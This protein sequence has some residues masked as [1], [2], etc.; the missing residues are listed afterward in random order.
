MN[1]ALMNYLQSQQSNQPE[2]TG[3]AP[4]NPFD[5]GIRRAI[6]SAQESLGMT[7]KQ[8]DKALRRSILTFANHNAQQPKERGFFNNFASA[9]KSMSPAIMDYDQ[10]EDQ[11]LAENQNMANQILAYKAAEEAKQAGAE[12]Q[13][14]RRQHAENQLGEQKRY[15]NMM[16]DFQ[17]QKL[18]QHQNSPNST[19]GHESSPNADIM[20]ILNNAEKVL[21]ADLENQDTY[22]GRTSNLLSRFTPGGYVPSKS[23]A[24]VNAMGDVLR[25]RLFNLWGYRNQ[26]EFEHVPSISADNPPE[27]NL[28]IIK[29]LKNQLAGAQSNPAEIEPNLQN[30]DQSNRQMNNNSNQLETITM[31]DS[32]GARYKIPIS[33]ADAAVSDGL[34]PVQ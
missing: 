23:Q 26:A 16:G 3:Q 28:E 1:P 27:V 19:Q 24:Q 31:Q 14:W 25:G 6:S 17:R 5:A 22:R 29:T 7:D 32:S 30:I 33:E 13:A 11:A 34:I 12:E 21:T 8:Q 15:H 18:G 20:N 2:Q 9:A 10:S 4:F